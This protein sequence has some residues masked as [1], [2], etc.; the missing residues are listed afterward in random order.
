MK[1]FEQYSDMI[2]RLY[3]QE[4]GSSDKRIL[5]RT[6]T[7]QVTDA[8]NLDCTY[9]YQI[10]KGTRVMKFETAKK[11][12]DML[13][14]NDE[15]LAGY[16]D[17][18]I[19]P[20]IIIEFIGGEPFLQVDLIEQICDYFVDKAIELNHKWAYNFAIS[21]CSNGVLYFDERVQRF[22][23]K[24]KGK[25]SFSITI[26]GNKELHDSCRVFPNGQPSYD[27]AVAGANDWIARGNY[28]GSKITIAPENLPYLYGAILH[29]VELGYHDINA[30]VVYENVW[31]PHHAKEYYKQLIKIADYFIDNNL[32][33]DY[34]LALF[35]NGFFKP[36]DEEDNENW[37]FKAGT[38]VLTPSGNRNIEELKIGDEVITGSGNIEKVE[39]ILNRH[40][41]DT[42]N[43]K[44]AGIG[45]IYTTSEHPFLAKQFLYIGNK[46][47]RHFSEPRWIKASDL[48]L[49]DKVAIYKHKFGS[50][51]INKHLAYIVGR[52]LGD[53]WNSTTGYKI[54]CSHN[55]D[56]V[57]ELSQALKD[58]NIN[59][60]IS[61]HRTVKQFNIYKNN[62]ELLSIISD[63]GVYAHGKR[64]P[65]VV[66]SWDKES[67][68][69]LLDGLFDADGYY[70][71]NDKKIKYNTVSATL[72]Y[73][74]CT[75]LRGLGYYPMCSLYKRKGQQE[76][77]GRVVNIR[78]RYDIYYYLNPQRTARCSY[79]EDNDVIWTTVYSSEATEPYE[80]YNLTVSN[81]HTFVANG[82]VVHNCGGTGAMLSCDPD[83]YLYPCI[84]YMESS[85]GCSQK[86]MR[87][88]NV[89]EGIAQREEYKC[90][91][92][93]LDCITRRSQST[94]ECYYCPIAKGCSWCFKAGTMITTPNGYVPIE[95]LKIGDEVI[96]GNGNIEKVENVMT[97]NANDT[98]EIKA[99]GMPPLYTTSEHP[100]LA[101]NYHQSGAKL[102]Y[103]EPV[104]T[105]AGKL[106]K[107]DK[108]ALFVRKF[109]DIDIDK[110]IA[111]LVGRYIGDGWK[112][113][114]VRGNCTT[115]G[116]G[117]CCSY[118]DC[119]EVEK[120]FDL[121]KVTYNKDKAKRTAQ[122][123]DIHIT[124][125]NLDNNN[126][127]LVS[128][129]A[130]CGRYAYGKVV[131]NEVFT[132][133][134]ESIEAFLKGYFDADAYYDK[135]RDT[136]KFCTV[137]EKLAF[138]IS[139]LLLMFGKKC[140]WGKKN[141]GTQIIEGRTVNTRTAYELSF[142]V[143][144]PIRKYYEFDETNSI[145][146]VN[147]KSVHSTEPYE[148]YNLTVSNEHTFIANGAIVHNCS[149]YNFQETGTP[150]KRVTY[151]CDMHKARSLAN[152][153]YW[154]T[155]Y[156]KQN[157][158]ERFEMHCPKEW[159]LEII[160]EEEYDKLLK[161]SLSASSDEK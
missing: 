94:D 1:Q 118:D 40:A 98:I 31:K 153:Y 128:I 103:D 140:N 36:M 137:S 72:A 110:N 102:I 30:N 15:R 47:V 96:A 69:S 43:V 104:W 85:L 83:G 142:L 84:R 55:E 51:H 134:K 60:S 125:H 9:C 65:R 161:L 45:S 127:L 158:D 34:F 79:D 115:I 112:T 52:Y 24:Y 145:M 16:V 53:G 92:D 89:D 5:S 135:K 93:C 3:P 147:I 66:F 97:R 8:C 57:E 2:A 121:A 116:Y 19:S 28:M 124:N 61:N 109:G 67:V 150:N 157:K 42:C 54:C 149:A 38:K 151:I 80:V 143:R 108:I 50:V 131:P 144:E 7:F 41:E 82:V 156:R 159:A 32:V 49:G 26:D 58:A 62:T 100:F 70:D 154:N 27:L 13:L 63:A 87:I 11:L 136:I 117:L 37:C 10:N 56:D 71:A 29:M 74:V 39:N 101:R 152:V 146:W 88:G 6:V 155:W 160:S 21:I 73:D 44:V 105:E 126:E 139:E 17:D 77:E 107:S 35:D 12:I 130:N 122:Q 91:V 129:L 123:Y 120:Y 59:F 22:L 132:W 86:P 133:N 111:Y 76:I 106:K 99:T 18:E 46:G 95:D 25:I 64:I 33:E 75:L 119:D 20:A 4:H 48:K 113:V 90:N 114:Q 148:V 81:E 141:G 138:G 23:N 78:D 14:T 68:I